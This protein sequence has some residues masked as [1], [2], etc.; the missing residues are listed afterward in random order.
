MTHDPDTLR[1]T[2]WVILAVMIGWSI[3]SVALFTLVQR[4]LATTYE[5]KGASTVLRSIDSLL[6]ND[7]RF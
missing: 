4:F 2:L 5:S 3:A 7:R 6:S 1:A